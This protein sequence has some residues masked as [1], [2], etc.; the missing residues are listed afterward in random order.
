MTDT[1]NFLITA[2]PR[3]GTKFIAHTLNNSKKFNVIHDLNYGQNLNKFYKLYNN[4]KIKECVQYTLDRFKNKNNKGEVSGA[5]RHILLSLSSIDTQIKKAV[6]LRHPEKM[7]V[8]IANMQNI[9]NAMRYI[10][11]MND[12]I[13]RLDDI[14]T[15]KDIKVFK[16]QN[17]I[18][19]KKYLQEILDYF[20]I[21]D[22]N[23]DNVD[24]SKKINNR[25]KKHTINDF[26]K[27]I[28]NKFREDIDWF[29]EKYS[30]DN[31]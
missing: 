11:I 24:I 7:V 10:D 25:Q 27:D 1:N 26:P 6:I 3:S 19:N 28:I 23:I 15:H 4:D 8:S 9:P 21:N 18:K 13:K 22:I 14:S 17:F 16:F 20:N 30:L 5:F 29:V 31:V 12:E 2:L